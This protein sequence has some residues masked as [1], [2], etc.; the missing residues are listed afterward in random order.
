MNQREKFHDF[1]INGQGAP[2]HMEP[3]PLIATYER[4]KNEGLRN[5]LSPYQYDEWCDAFRLNHWYTV[6]KV[7]RPVAPLFE[8]EII[9]ESGDTVTKR[10]NDGSI[11]M[12]NKI[13]QQT[14]PHEIRPAVTTR[15]EWERYKDWMEVDA[16]L[17]KSDTQWVI[18]TFNQATHSED[19][20]SLFAGSIA[21]TTRNLLGFEAFA[22]MPYDDPEWLEE[23]IET[24]FLAAEWQIKAFGENGIPVDVVHFWEDICFKNG[25]IMSPCFFREFAVPRYAKLSKLARSYGYKIISV[26]SDGDIH[27]LIDEWLNGG[28]N[29]LC[30]LEVQAGM[31]INLLQ[32]K[33]PDCCYWT[34]G[35]NKSKLA[36]SKEAIV[37][38]LKRIKPAVEKGGYIP[39]LD[40]NIPADVSFDNYLEYLELKQKI[41]GIGSGAPESNQIKG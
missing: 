14:I 19:P 29:L 13:G 30:P 15:E 40:H 31:D 22:M 41:L 27:A 24:H 26:D 20:V 8:E 3:G 17:P 35:V 33:Y 23:M 34:G 9:E 10:M 38:E 18:D 2:P 25:P 37:K 28:V 4:W 5:D 12:N 1:M 32:E 16:P 39:M 7:N 36:E 21:G 6:V 11:S